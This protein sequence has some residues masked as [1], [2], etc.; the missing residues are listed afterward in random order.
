MTL[1]AIAPD[2]ESVEAI[3]FDGQGLKTGWFSNHALK[4]IEIIEDPF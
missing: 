4:E 1:N 2:N 3:W